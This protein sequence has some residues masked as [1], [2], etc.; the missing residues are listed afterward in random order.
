[1]PK[2]I[3]ARLPLKSVVNG[4][5]RCGLRFTKDWQSFASLDEATVARLKTEQML[6]VSES[7]PE[8]FAEETDTSSQYLAPEDRPA[9]IE[10][11]IAQLDPTAF[12]SKGVPKT[13]ALE[14]IL[15]FPVSAAERDAAWAAAQAAQ[16]G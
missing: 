8:G 7:P 5:Y 2:I 12:T 6:E 15:G 13:D 14:K 4:F 9:A 10:A 11:V 3:Y 1:M 16:R